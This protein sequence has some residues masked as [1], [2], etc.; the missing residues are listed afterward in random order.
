[1]AI[2][3]QIIRRIDMAR[4]LAAL[5][6]RFSKEMAVLRDGTSSDATRNR[7]DDQSKGWIYRREQGLIN[8][9]LNCTYDPGIQGN[10]HQ[11]SNG[12]ARKS[13][14]RAVCP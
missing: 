5:K 7:V 1:M 11:G 6:V 9:Q 13:I 8:G 14:C 12:F 3:T 10:F 4:R 2:A